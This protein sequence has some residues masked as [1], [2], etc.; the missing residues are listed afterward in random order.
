MSADAKFEGGV[1]AWLSGL[2]LVRDAVRQQLVHRQLIAHIP[3]DRGPLRVLDAGCGQGTQA[4]A[5]ARLGHEVVGLDL[6]NKL[7]GEA[8]RAAGEEPAGVR[9]RL[10][11]L[12]GD[13]MALG[14]EHLG[15]YDIVCC[16]GVA[17]YLPSLDST[18]A[19]LCRVCRSGGLVSVLTRNRAGIA[20]RAGMTGDW[21][22]TLRAFDARD[23]T[24]RLGIAAVRA[25]E[26]GEVHA[27][28]AASGASVVAW[29]GVRLFT[30]HWGREEPG[31]DF[32]QLLAAE[33][34]AG[35]REPYRS[36][37]ALTHTVACSDSS[38]RAIRQPRTA[39]RQ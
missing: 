33:E 10:E 25:D 14:T 16:H 37:A 18:I 32:A 30:D 1:D 23:Y 7:L 12:T 34:E 2:G 22:G 35:R 11:F 24:N 19:A 5:L 6:S 27:A 3:P 21:A 31:P 36:L 39:A 4:L 29:Y 13:L 9:R 15:R 8:R 26:P 20:M 17:M 38:A 28:L